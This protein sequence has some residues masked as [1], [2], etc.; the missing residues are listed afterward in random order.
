MVTRAYAMVCPLD[1]ILDHRA[2]HDMQAFMNA[3]YAVWNRS[4]KK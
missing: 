4:E 1:Y 3:L 2:D